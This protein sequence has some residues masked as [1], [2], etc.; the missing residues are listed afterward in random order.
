MNESSIERQDQ[1]PALPEDAI[2]WHDGLLLEAA[3]FQ[4]MCQRQE[5]LVSYHVRSA[6][7]YSWGVRRLAIEDAALTDNV[8]TIR[9]LEALMPDGLVVSH[10]AAQGVL[11]LKL[12]EEL[13]QQLAASRRHATICLAVPVNDDIDADEGM[14]RYAPAGSGA[15]SRMRPRLRLA[16]ASEL[17]KHAGDTVLPLARIGFSLNK[18]VLLPFLPPLLDIGVAPLAAGSPSL[19]ANSVALVKTMQR[20]ANYLLDAA[21]KP[22]AGIEDKVTRLELR[23]RLAS[24]SAGIP[25]LR[26]LLSLPAVAPL[27]LYLAWCGAL[28]PLSA[29]DET[30]EVA[31]SAF[32]AYRHDELAYTFGKLFERVNALLAMAD[33]PFRELALKVNNDHQYSHV[34]DKA[35]R[36]VWPAAPLDAQG[37]A[38]PARDVLIVGIRGMAQM[39]ADQWLKLAVITDAAAQLKYRMGRRMGAPRSVIKPDGVLVSLDADAPQQ[40]HKVDARGMATPDICLYALD[41]DESLNL[42]GDIV[43]QNAAERQPTEVVLF[44]HK[45]ST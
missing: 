8:F 35:N 26:G 19:L 6:S 20:S 28:G 22:P 36:Y 2:W 23:Q 34:F 24:V 32:P 14:A 3:H 37:S 41:L 16:L 10:A 29:L 4:Q 43:L 40:T 18:F 1:H 31:R 39:E 13:G 27:P 5:Q 30:G 9:E 7:P 12:G 42:E 11:E 45:A 33:R 44:I 17:D 25:I 15:I 38:A 21:L